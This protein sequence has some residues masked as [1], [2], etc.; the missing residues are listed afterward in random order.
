MLVALVLLA[1][2]LWSSVCF[3]A[4]AAFASAAHRRRQFEREWIGRY[5]RRN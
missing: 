1:L 5:T 4:G 2:W 3:V